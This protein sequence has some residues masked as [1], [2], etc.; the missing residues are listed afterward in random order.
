MMIFIWMKDLYLVFSIFLPSCKIA[1][2]SETEGKMKN[3][4]IVSLKF[5]YFS[6]LFEGPRGVMFTY[7]NV[8]GINLALYYSTCLHLAFSSFDNI[9]HCSWELLCPTY[10]YLHKPV[11]KKV[12]ATE[13]LTFYNY[14]NKS[15]NFTNLRLVQISV[16]LAFWQTGVLKQVCKSAS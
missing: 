12:G 11:C 2:I 4:E 14:F 13:I 5:R 9:H 3:K 10:A 1:K 8:S 6:N 7:T 15:Q 16:V